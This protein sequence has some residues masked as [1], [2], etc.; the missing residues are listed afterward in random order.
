MPDQSLGSSKKATLQNF[1]TP[2][3]LAIIAFITHFWYFRS[4]GLYEDDWF[5]VPRMFW[6]WEKIGRQVIEHFIYWPDGRP[7]HHVL[8]I[9][10]GGLNSA[11]GGLPG[12]Y[13]GGCLIVVTNTLLF[14]YLVKRCLPQ[15]VAVTGALTFCLFPADTTKLFINNFHSHQ[16]ALMFLLLASLCYLTRRRVLSYFLITASLLT[17]ETTFWP[18][19][20]VPLLQLN[21]TKERFRQLAWHGLILGVIFTS[22]TILRVYLGESRVGG[23][24]QAQDFWWKLFK[25]AVAMWDGPMVS[26]GLTAVRPLTT[27]RWMT[28]DVGALTAAVFLL[29]L[30][31]LWRESPPQ[32]ANI[33]L[34]YSRE[35]GSPQISGGMAVPKSFQEPLKIGL[36]GLILTSLNYSLSF[37]HFPVDCISGI[38]SGSAHMAATFGAALLASSLSTVLLLWAQSH[39]RK[40]C[41]ILAL[42]LFF[43]LLAGFH[44]LVQ[45]DFVRGWAFQKQFWS[46][47]LSLCPDLTEGTLIFV[48]DEGGLIH[49]DYFCLHSWNNHVTLEK[50][51]HFPQEWKNPPRL[52]TVDKNWIRKTFVEGNNIRWGEVTEFIFHAK[53]IV[54]PPENLILLKATPKGL[55]RLNGT[56][57]I[58]GLKFPLKEPGPNNIKHF[59]RTP[60]FDLLIHPSVMHIPLDGG[61]LPPAWNTVWPSIPR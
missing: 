7:L 58:S 54:L 13:L 18:F 41:A 45:K 59:V 35:V 44:V 33:T 12:I 40:N 26:L 23:L 25:N 56:I 34:T 2:V 32:P 27:I 20:G 9:T 5:Q 55:I 6:S 37:Y 50:I 30:V 36:V 43:S 61:L 29:S 31:L 14:Y 48:E 53:W 4:F 57:Y 42:A 11:W 10:I 3:V 21:W 28:W 47:V 39:R 52:F 15:L 16:T 51:I 49:M 19:L 60:I 24:L 38:F 8:P 17:Y 22:I 1:L 46:N